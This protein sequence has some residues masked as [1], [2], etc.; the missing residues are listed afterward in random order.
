MSK[1]VKGALIAGI[2][3]VVA[4]VIGYFAAIRPVQLTISATETAEAR[5][6]LNQQAATGDDV[7]NDL[8]ATGQTLIEP[9][10]DALV[11]GTIDQPGL[12][13]YAWA[14]PYVRDF[15][16][17][18]WT[19]GR[20]VYALVF[21]CGP[22]DS[23]A[24]AT[25][26]FEVSEGISA[27]AGILYLRLQGI[28]VDPLVR[29]SPIDTIRTAQPTAASVTRT[30]LSETQVAVTLEH[31]SATVSWDGGPA[32]SLYAGDPYQPVIDVVPPT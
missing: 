9:T 32:V 27:V 16:P 5:A 26:D 25:H 11:Q 21:T 17:G 13:P 6:T 18:F 14:V 28:F 1:T 29:F 30:G 24:E 7:K 2:A 12:D 8:G 22:G 3:V 4:A 10:V 19:P 31:C 15:P 20:H 23:L